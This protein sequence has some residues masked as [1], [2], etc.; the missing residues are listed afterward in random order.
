MKKV[1]QR[2]ELLLESTHP[3]VPMEKQRGADSNRRMTRAIM[4][5]RK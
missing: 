1:K 2:K 3:T 4:A 5:K